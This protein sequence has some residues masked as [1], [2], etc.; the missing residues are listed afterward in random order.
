MGTLGVM[1]D[2]GPRAAK[3]RH[4]GIS[5]GADADCDLPEHK[6]QGPG[7]TQNYRDA[8]RKE[9]RKHFTGPFATAW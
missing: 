3:C 1:D 4:W 6:V 7:K 8:C 5:G 2:S 9:N